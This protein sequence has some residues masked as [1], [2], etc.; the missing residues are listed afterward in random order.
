MGV[1]AV[2]TRNKVLDH[3]TGTATYAAVTPY[4][5]LYDGDPTGAGAEIETPTQNGYNRQTITMSA[6]SSGAITNSAAITW[7]PATAAWGDVTYVAA[8]DA[9]TGGNLLWYDDV[10][11]K[12]VGSGDSYQIAA[13]DLDLT[14]T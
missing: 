6:A 12:T 7:G 5:A 1:F 8:F 2:A 10:A 9:A 4:L 14:L 11:T 13:G 3:V